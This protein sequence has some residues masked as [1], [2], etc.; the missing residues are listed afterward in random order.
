MPWVG[1]KLEDVL[2]HTLARYG[3]LEVQQIVNTIVEHHP[4]EWR[5]AYLRTYPGTQYFVGRKAVDCL[6]M[7]SYSWCY[8]KLVKQEHQ[9]V[10][11]NK[12][13]GQGHRHLWRCANKGEVEALRKELVG[14]WTCP[15]ELRAEIEAAAEAMS[16]SVEFWMEV[17]PPGWFVECNAWLIVTLPRGEVKALVKSRNGWHDAAVECGLL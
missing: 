14:R 16:G 7:C 2:L 15:P 6:C 9:R 17:N 11:R 1:T 12:N 8:S 3:P 5:A 13:T 10:L 4:D